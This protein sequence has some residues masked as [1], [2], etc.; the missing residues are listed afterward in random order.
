MVS[1]LEA[2][3][4]TVVG[5]ALI[6]TVGFGGGGPAGVTSTVALAVAGVVPAAPVAV[7]T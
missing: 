2:P 1:V 3:S 7:T 6:V 5:L 4:A